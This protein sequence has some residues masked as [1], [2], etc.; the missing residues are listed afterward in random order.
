MSL[1]EVLDYYLIW[2]VV[3]ILNE[4]RIR[5]FWNAVNIKLNSSIFVRLGLIFHYFFHLTP[6]TAYMPSLELANEM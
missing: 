4:I 5:I 6:G 2:T 3:A 1:I